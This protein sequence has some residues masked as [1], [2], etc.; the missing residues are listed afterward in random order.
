MGVMTRH[1][2]GPYV[3]TEPTEVDEAIDITPE[4]VNRLLQFL[5]GIFDFV[6]V[7]CGGQL[8]GCTMSIL[9]NANLTIFTMV[10]SL[11]TIKT[12]KR[13]LTAMERKGIRKDRL[14][15]VVNR[16]LPKADI[17]IKDAERVLGQ[18]VYATVPNDYEDI[19]SSINK[20]IPLIKLMPRA[21][22]SK[23][24][25]SLVNLLKK[26]LGE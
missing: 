12:A 21:P 23:A 7:D 16:Y 1:S 2:S 24:F 17:Q 19:I 26:D 5:K 11:P 4:Q 22:A 8:A 20:G 3:L 10:L 25:E 9:E 14:R 18:K 13:Y 15:L 6:V